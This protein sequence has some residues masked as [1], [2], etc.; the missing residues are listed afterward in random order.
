MLI[1]EEG[2]DDLHFS[3]G[4][5]FGLCKLGG[6]CG[7]GAAAELTHDP[8]HFFRHDYVLA[9]KAAD[10][11]GGEGMDYQCDCGKL[12]IRLLF[13]GLRQQASFL[14]TATPPT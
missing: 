8:V 3:S 4:A 7:R 6:H 2:V 9:V 1:C 10:F 12:E 13:V 5:D 11:V 14:S